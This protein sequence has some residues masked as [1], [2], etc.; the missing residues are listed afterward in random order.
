[1]ERPRSLTRSRRRRRTS[2]AESSER[3]SEL[4]QFRSPQLLL[5]CEEELVELR[6]LHA[7]AGT[8]ACACRDGG[9]VLE[10]MGEIAATVEARRP[11][12]RGKWRERPA[13]PRS[14]ARTTRSAAG[15]WRAVWDRA[16]RRQ[17]SRWLVEMRRCAGVSLQRVD[18]IEIDDENMVERGA[19][20]GEEAGA[21]RGK[22]LRCQRLA[23]GA[24]DGWQAL[25]WAI[26]RNGW[27]PRRTIDR[28]YAAC[29]RLRST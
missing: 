9:L 29:A 2:A 14:G 21:R 28:S 6:W 20:R 12:D 1:M 7:R 13:S 23:G 4:A 25:L 27:Q 5:T 19:Q 10:E 16:T 15:R 11:V 22:L 17:R 18:V 8:M 24:G 3:Q 26:G